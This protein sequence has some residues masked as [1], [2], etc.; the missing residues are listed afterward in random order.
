MKNFH[1]LLLALVA[2][3]VWSV[4]GCASQNKGNARS[5]ESGVAPAPVQSPGE[6]SAGEKS[7]DKMTA[8]EEALF[9]DEW[10]TSKDTEEQEVHRVADPIEPFNR[11]MFGFNDTMYEWLWRPLSLG[12]RKVTPRM[13]RTGIQNF[14]TNLGAPVRTAGCI[15]QGKGQ[16][17]RAPGSSPPSA[18]SASSICSKTTRK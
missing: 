4:L 11:V 13:M 14:F 16:A 2:V 5:Q 12:Y 9:E 1:W 18:F 3:M 10:D 8:E 15:F 6:V 7:A 17:A